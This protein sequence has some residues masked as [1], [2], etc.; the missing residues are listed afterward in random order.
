MPRQTFLTKEAFVNTTDHH[1]K[2][3]LFSLPDVIP[4]V[5]L[6]GENKLIEQIRFAYDVSEKQNYFID[7][8]VLTV[9]D[10][11]TRLWL[12]ASHK[13]GK[14]FQTDPQMA[15]ALQ[16]IAAAVQATLR[17]EVFYYPVKEEKTKSVTKTT[18]FSSV[19]TGFTFLFLKKKFS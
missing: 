3:I 6:I 1:L 14:A 2:Q 19:K 13:D 8:S 9:N 4:V 11:Y 17:G 12:H 15:L 10:Q 7:V 18:W 5:S 16:D